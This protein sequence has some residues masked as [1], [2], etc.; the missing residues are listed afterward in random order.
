[1]QSTA[2]GFTKALGQLGGALAGY[3]LGLLADRAGW[4][5]VMT[6][7]AVAATLSALLALPLWNVQA[8]DAARPADAT[9]ARKNQ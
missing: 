5:A 3:P 2:G 1:M 4:S 7:A 9:K 8:M 6:A